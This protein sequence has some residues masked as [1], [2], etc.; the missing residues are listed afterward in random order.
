MYPFYT[1]KNI[2]GILYNDLL[3]EGINI[4]KKKSGNMSAELTVG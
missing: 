4:N 2:R 1:C 3:G